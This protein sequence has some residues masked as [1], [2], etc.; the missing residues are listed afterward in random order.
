MDGTLFNLLN[1]DDINFKNKLVFL[2]RALYD[3]TNLIQE[4]QDK[5]KFV[6]H[7][8]KCDNIFYKKIDDRYNFYLGDFDNSRIQIDNYVIKNQKTVI[9]DNNFYC[10]K[11]LFILTN[12]L[13]YSFNDSNW[14][15]KFFYKFP[16]IKNIINNQKEFH[17]LYNYKDEDINDIYIPSNYIIIIKQMLKKLI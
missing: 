4:L 7:D 17:T 12:S 1:Q 14:K 16:I 8:L 13:F 10:K 9:P 5:I 3:I 6:H 11:D 2:L 15:E